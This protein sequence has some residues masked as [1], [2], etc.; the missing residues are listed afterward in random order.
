MQREGIEKLPIYPEERLTDH[1]ARVPRCK[2]DKEGGKQVQVP[3][4]RPGSGFTLM[5][6]GLLMLL[7][8]SMTVDQPTAPEF[9]SKVSIASQVHRMV[10]VACYDPPNPGVSRPRLL[11]AA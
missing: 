4:A 8:R 1:L 10:Q 5:F 9:R 6:E 2:C 3:W 7:V 11:R